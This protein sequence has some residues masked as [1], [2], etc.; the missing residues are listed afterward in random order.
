MPTGL[1]DLFPEVQDEKTLQKLAE[2]IR[3]REARRVADLVLAVRAVEAEFGLPAKE[4]IHRAFLKRA[5]EEGQRI[6]ARTAGT[7]VQDFLA[8]VEPGWAVTHEMT[9]VVDTA[10]RVS[11][12][13][14]KCM[15]AEECRRLGA[16][17]IG[18]WF[19]ES[20]GPCLR[21]FNGNLAFRRSR[22]LMD[23]DA[24]C[25]HEFTGS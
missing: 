10:Q 12:E 19:C 16:T 14:T 4:A 22:T 11:Y 6:A 23:G 24:S 13:F 3:Q 7:G 8:A 9:R 18:A 2:L 25:D 20:D 21:G 15:A 5:E 17:D 1:R